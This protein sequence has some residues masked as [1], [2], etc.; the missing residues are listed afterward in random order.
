MC[1]LISLT[2]VLAF[3]AALSAKSLEASEL[4]VSAPIEAYD[5]STSKITVMGHDYSTT[6]ENL[7]VGQIV[8]VYGV[9]AADGTTSET[10][11]EATGTF[12]SGTDSLFLKGV[13]TDSDPMLGRLE[14][15]G[16]TVDYTS[17]LSSNAFE[18]PAVGDVIAVSGSQPLIKGVVLAGAFG[19]AA[20]AAA[21]AAH[22]AHASGGGMS[23]FAVSGGGARRLATSGGGVGSQATSGGGVGS[24]AT[25]G[26]G[27]GSQATS[28]GGIGSQATSG[29]GVSA[30]ATSGGGVQ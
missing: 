24:Q 9:L 3:F 25:S 15:G 19:G 27:V 13:V 14:V 12:A 17:Q 28:G 23:S 4:L 22:T 8:N 26:G 6:A 18:A 2:I 11:V 20:Y 16:A 1:R 7:A 21:A 5:A 29:G 10:E 30:L